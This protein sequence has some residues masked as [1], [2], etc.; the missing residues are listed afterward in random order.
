M[1]NSGSPFCLQRR[2][3]ANTN[4]SPPLRRDKHIQLFSNKLGTARF[5]KKQAQKESDEGNEGRQLPNFV[6][7]SLCKFRR[8]NHDDTEH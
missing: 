7:V 8:V 3:R 4:P 1:N 2:E 6:L 5:Q